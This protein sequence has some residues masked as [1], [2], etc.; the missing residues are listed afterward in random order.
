MIRTQAIPEEVASKIWDILLEHTKLT[1][2]EEGSDHY[3]YDTHRS[4][5]VTTAVEG[6]WTEWRFW[7]GLGFGG[8]VRFQNG[9]WYVDCYPEDVTPERQEIMDNTNAA[10]SK[11]FEEH[12]GVK[13][14]A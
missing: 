6:R 13:P 10:L 12:F 3:V 7:G 2:P 5:F 8:K 9:R 11:L 14:R 1:R 4:S